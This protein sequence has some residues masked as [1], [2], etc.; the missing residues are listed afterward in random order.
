MPNN[1][2]SAYQQASSVYNDQS[3]PQKLLTRVDT[4][5]LVVCL[6]LHRVVN[7]RELTITA[8]WQGGISHHHVKEIARVAALEQYVGSWTF[9]VSIA[10]DPQG[11]IRTGCRAA[12]SGLAENTSNQ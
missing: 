10:D 9:S 2:F 5:S 6:A 4:G 11:S 1:H 7:P 3:G 12:Q 8:I